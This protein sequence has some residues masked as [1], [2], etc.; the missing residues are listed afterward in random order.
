MSRVE[1]F[2]SSSFMLSLL[3]NQLPLTRNFD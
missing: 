3:K 2:I 1:I